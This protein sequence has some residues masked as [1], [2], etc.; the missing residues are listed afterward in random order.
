MNS[1]LTSLTLA[2]L[3]AG[4]ATTAGAANMFR[5]P[6]KNLLVSN[7]PLNPGGPTPTEPETPGP[8]V[9]EPPPVIN[10][11]VLS[12]PL[13]FEQVFVG[14]SST[15]S[16]TVT[17]PNTSQ[18]LTVTNIS[19]D[20]TAYVADTSCLTL[21]APGAQCSVSITFAPQQTNSYSANLT[22]DFEGSKTVSTT[23]E[24][25][26]QANLV[27]ISG[28][29]QWSDGLLAASCNA[30]R[31]PTGSYVYQGATGDGVYRITPEGGSE[32]N[33]YCDMTTD[34]GGWTLVV[35]WN[36]LGPTVT[37]IKQ[38][39][40]MV[41]GSS[42]GG[43]S[44]DATRPAFS[45]TNRF[46]NLRFDSFNSTWNSLYA[47]A[48]TAGLK[49]ATWSVWPNITSAAQFRVNA[50]NLNG[51]TTPATASVSLYSAGWYPSVAQATNSA[52]WAF[53]LFTVDSNQGVCGGA[54][55]VGPQKICPA[56]APVSLGENN[57][58][59]ITS[60]KHLWGR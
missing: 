46:A 50:T 51:A 15:L 52:Q 43:W 8:I 49:F 41:R 53:G 18:A 12:G 55:I 5:V 10:D 1:K 58:H 54:G 47:T 40:V 35:R 13:D 42:L 38:G 39:N 44:N 16:L 22:L 23:L 37:S 48:P 27:N 3:L 11:L 33:V 57:H 21:L 28:A 6:L 31:N 20:S 59:D 19:T 36:D 17:N 14:D 25:V 56:L 32:Q 30:Y 7:T 9:T 24:G 4:A 45:G 26:A 60:L 34:G 2:L 29:R